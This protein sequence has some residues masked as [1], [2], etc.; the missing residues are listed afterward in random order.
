MLLY[1]VQP[2][3]EEV[4]PESP[5]EID[6]VT[7]DTTVE[8]QIIVEMAKTEAEIKAETQVVDNY[9]KFV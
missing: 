5:G 2:V 3:H 7:T 8:E 9:F 1:Q 6:L 4:R